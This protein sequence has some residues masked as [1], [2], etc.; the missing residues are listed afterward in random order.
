ML[1]HPGAAYLTLTFAKSNIEDENGI[2][3][4]NLA[5]L[6]N[7]KLNILSQ[8]YINNTIDVEL[9]IPHNIGEIEKKYGHSMKNV[10]NET[11]NC[12]IE[13]ASNFYYSVNLKN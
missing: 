8:S 4:R 7:L 6:Y 13:N 1:G 12:L 10:L 11:I 5:N 9:E 2:H 3:N